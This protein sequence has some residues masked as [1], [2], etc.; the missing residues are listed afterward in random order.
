MKV[1]IE[2]LV[3][4]LMNC[5]N[6]EKYLRDAIESV[7]AQTYQNWELI[8]WD[9]QSNDCSAEIFNSYIDKRLKYFYA[10][11]HSLL[12]EARNWAAEKSSGN[13]FAF[14]DVDDYWE[15]CKLEMQMNVFSTDKKNEKNTI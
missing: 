15:A 3:S 14:L 2:P 8:F 11:K 5:Y 13:Y 6:G 10:P 9:N 1:P 12:Y 7:L 4:I